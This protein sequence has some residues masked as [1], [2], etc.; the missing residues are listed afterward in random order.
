VVA[1]EVTQPVVDSSIHAAARGS[2]SVA[3]GATKGITKIVHD[4][5]L[6]AEERAA[7]DSEIAAATKFADAAAQRAGARDSA[8]D[9]WHRAYTIQSAAIGRLKLSLDLSAQDL[10]AARDALTAARDT[11]TAAAARLRA[12]SLRFAD[13]GH[14]V[15]DLKKEAT[16]GDP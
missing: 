11:L 2:T 1:A 6:I 13:L 4:S 9:G 10:A 14:L 5:G 7:A 8:A 12:D 3:R 15:A 16:R